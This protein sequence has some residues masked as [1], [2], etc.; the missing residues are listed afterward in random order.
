MPPPTTQQLPGLLALPAPPVNQG[1]H[2]SQ[3]LPGN[4][5]LFG[6]Q[7]LFGP[8]NAVANHVVAM[9][10][11]LVQTKLT[12]YE[13]DSGGESSVE[14]PLA[15]YPPPP[16]PNKRQ[17]TQSETLDKNILKSP[18]AAR[19]SGSPIE[20]GVPRHRQQASPCL[21][22]CQGVLLPGQMHVIATYGGQV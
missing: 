21:C 15:K 6:I 13:E 18:A 12:K 19:Q 10:N 14:L 3:A 16:H 22:K 20:L 2:G 4:Q 1:L 5:G 11:V 17:I 8:Q 9:Q 7:G